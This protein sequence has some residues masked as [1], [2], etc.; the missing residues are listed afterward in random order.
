MSK[1][2]QLHTMS[3]DTQAKEFQG[4]FKGYLVTIACCVFVLWNIWYCPKLCHA[5]S[6]MLLQ[7]DAVQL[8]PKPLQ[9]F[10]ILSRLLARH[11]VHQFAAKWQDINGGA[12]QMNL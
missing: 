6:Y 5:S 8:L 3:T 10:G 1:V 4:C 11:I 9:V 2:A 7:E 12:V